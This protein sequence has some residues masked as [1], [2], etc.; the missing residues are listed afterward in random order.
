MKHTA[1]MV[2][3]AAMVPAA[4]QEPKNVVDEI[5]TTEQLARQ[6]RGLELKERE[7]ELAHRQKM[8]EL[9]LEQRRVEIDRLR[10]Q[11]VRSGKKEGGGVLLLLVLAI[12]ILLTVWVYKDMREQGIG[13]ALW[14]PIVL[15][16]GIFGAL[17]YALVRV[18]DTRARPAE[19]AARPKKAT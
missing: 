4:A 15:L 17:L 11:G 10:R 5:P 18:A 8:R 9:E 16:A 2:I 12:N 13:R 14:I 3:L 19:A 7:A 6:E 1:W